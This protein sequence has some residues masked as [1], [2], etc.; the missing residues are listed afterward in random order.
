MK[1][2]VKSSVQE[3]YQSVKGSTAA[4][5]GNEDNSVD[6]RMASKAQNIVNEVSI[7]K[8]LRAVA[9]FHTPKIPAIF[10]WESKCL[11]SVIIRIC[12]NFKFE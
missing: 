12:L 3:Q 4:P 6:I 11:K 2:D 5:S 1:N 10:I 9:Y 8:F 7:I